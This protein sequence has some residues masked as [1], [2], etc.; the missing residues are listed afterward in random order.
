MSKIKVGIIGVGTIGKRVAD[1]V[2]LQDDMELAGITVGSYNYRAIVAAQKKVPLFV[3]DDSKENFTKNG[4]PI[5]GDINELLENVDIVVDCA[6]KKVGAADKEKYYLPKKIKA[7]FQG[8]E[9]AKVAE[10]S[11]VA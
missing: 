8:G 4:I 11:F 3:V 7:I 6:P 2:M 9:K 1:A 5:E 10:C